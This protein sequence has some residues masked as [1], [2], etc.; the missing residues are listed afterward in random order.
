MHGSP[1]ARWPP[2]VA[3][4][5]TRTFES[6]RSVRAIT[7]KPLRTAGECST[8]RAAQARRCAARRRPEFDA[9]EP[10]LDRAQA[11]QPTG[12]NTPAFIISINAV[13]RIGAS[14]GIIGIEQRDRLAQRSGSSS[15]KGVIGDPLA[16]GFES[17]FE[18]LRELLFHLPAL[19]F[20][21]GCPMAPSFPSGPCPLYKK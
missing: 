8:S 19:D 17:R 16:C 3:T 1:C 11:D 14:R 4:F 2:M 18:I 13:R 5:L 7:G 10:A 6:V 15:S 20:S 9:G 21:T 12:L